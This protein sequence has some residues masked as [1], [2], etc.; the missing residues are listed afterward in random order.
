MNS[1]QL[2]T[3]GML[4]IVVFIVMIVAVSYWYT[5]NPDDG[6]AMIAMSGMSMGMMTIVLIFAV[7]YN[8][9]LRNES[10]HEEYM[11]RMGRCTCGGDLDEDGVCT[12]CG[13]KTGGSPPAGL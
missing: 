1:T 9:Q 3:V 5:T 12:K 6:S 8:K 10:I 2:R 13:K 11:A 7:I 4:L